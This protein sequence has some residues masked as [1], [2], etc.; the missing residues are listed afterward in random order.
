MPKV[1]VKY[2][3]Y[4]YIYSKAVD[5]NNL[6]ECFSAHEPFLNSTNILIITAVHIATG[7]VDNQRCPKRVNKK[8][9]KQ[10][11][12][13]IIRICTIIQTTKQTKQTESK[14]EYSL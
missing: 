14:L 1:N 7:V 8:V 4:V 6:A 12:S 3:K 11:C 2:R 9:H 10:E 5:N 13:Y